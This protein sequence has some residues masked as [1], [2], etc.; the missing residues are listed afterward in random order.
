LRYIL[1]SISTLV[2]DSQTRLTSKERYDENVIKTFAFNLAHKLV[3]RLSREASRP[4][5]RLSN[6]GTPCARKLWYSINTPD[7]AEPLAASTRL[8][9]L[10]GDVWEEVLLF[11]AAAAGHRVE[12]QQQ[13][14]TLHGVLGH[15]DATID[16]ELVDSKSA[17]TYSFRKFKEG[18]LAEDDAFGYRTQLGGYLASLTS[19]DHDVA[20]DRAHFLVGDK[21]LGHI[22][23]DTHKR[24]DIV[25]PDDFEQ[26]VAS[27]RKMLDWPKPPAREYSDRAEGSSGN[28]SLGVACSYCPFK[29]ECWPGLRAYK[30]AKG[31]KFL[32]NV[33]REPDVPELDINAAQED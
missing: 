2:K 29:R 27:R 22:T 32:T 11:L 26:L 23:L 20:R 33:A 5:L 6:L 8:K 9:F 28:R 1:K 3:D 16:G 7:K 30:Y 19:V 4:S 10:L 24:E 25:P 13:E 31:P 21:T 14:V 12:R 15:I 17:S 18:R